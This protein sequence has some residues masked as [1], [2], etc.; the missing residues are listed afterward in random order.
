M[1]NILKCFFIVFVLFVSCNSAQ[2]I[3]SEQSFNNPILPYGADPYS[4]YKDGFYYYTHTMQNNLTLFKT[5]NLAN[6]QNAEKKVIW[7]P[8]ANTMYSKEIWAP[9]IQFL[10]GKWYFY[11]AADDGNNHNH[12]MYVLENSNPDP[13]QGEW[14]FKGKVGDATD[15]WAIDADV[16]DYN[17]QLFMAWS[18]WEGDENGMQNIY[19]AKMSNPW[20]IEGPRV[21]IAHPTYD[22]ERN[23]YLPHETP[24]Y[25]YVNEGPQFLQHGNRMFIIF[26]A[27]GCWTDNYTLGM[28][29]APLD[30]DWM[31]PQSWTKH[32]E[33]V[34]KP[35]PGSGVYAAGH[36]SFFKSADGK[37]DWI[38]YHA[39]DKP[40]QGCGRDRKPRM[41]KFTWDD[42][43]FPVFGSPVSTA[44]PLALPASR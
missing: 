15:K 43:G 17:G 7:T 6:I 16:V 23:G 38:L 3:S 22:W 44:I 28:M 27:S 20:T 11:F 21:K 26:S 37:E 1:N 36:N 35:E 39:N 12:R 13:M 8:P 30:A 31:N 4:F 10:R 9:Q 32:P 40:G 24:P 25:V 29:Y 41:Q 14:I 34:F 18:G 19:L 2:K 42:N 5:E 33:P